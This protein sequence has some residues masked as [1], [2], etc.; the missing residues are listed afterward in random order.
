MVVGTIVVG[1]MI[2]GAMIVGAII[3]GAIIVG[4]M[5]V[6][7]MSNDRF[8]KTSHI[9]LLLIIHRCL[10]RQSSGFGSRSRRFE[11]N[12]KCFFPIHV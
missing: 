10:L 2:V 1:A 11:R 4:A 12:R 5:I 9:I 7:A 8:C 3:V 6:G